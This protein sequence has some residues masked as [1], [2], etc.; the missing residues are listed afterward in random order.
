MTLA[1]WYSHH[2]L[3]SFNLSE[4]I[5][6]SLYNN[7]N[8]ELEGFNAKV[9]LSL[10]NHLTDDE[11]PKRSEV[12]NHN[13]VLEGINWKR[14]LACIS[15]RIEYCDGRS[16]ITILKNRINW[17]STRLST[18]KTIR[19]PTQVWMNCKISH[20]AYEETI[21]QGANHSTLHL[22]GSQPIWQV[23]TFKVNL[24]VQFNQLTLPDLATPHVNIT[25][26]HNVT[27]FI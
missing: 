16:L 15:E 19:F 1:E 4:Q 21:S 8:F 20:L 10:D 26:H 9:K 24:Y 27:W 6:S 5:H 12:A 25:T 23:V 7:K 17:P 13:A 14:V 2:N 11:I 18:V 22:N 3:L